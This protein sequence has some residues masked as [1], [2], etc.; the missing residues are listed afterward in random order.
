MRL[1]ALIMVAALAGCSAPPPPP[2]AAPVDQMML[3]EARAGGLAFA[4]DRPAEAVT[5]YRAAL[6]RARLRDDL[7]SITDA[8]TNLAVAE[9]RANQPE[10]ALADARATR[11]ELAR[12]GAADV[13]VLDLVE[14]TALY[15]TGQT[16]AADQMASLV[17]RAGDP[18][19]AARASFLRGLIADAHGDAAGLAAA[20]QALD[21]Q[22]DSEQAADATELESRQQLRLRNFAAARTYAEQAASLRR[23]LPDYRGLARDLALAAQAAQ[24]QGD[25]Q[26][27][28]D[29]Y[30]RAGRSA[31]VQGN[32]ADARIWLQHAQSG[33]PA[34]AEQA[35]QILAALAP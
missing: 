21:P 35:R 15:R 3:N 29:L 8:G 20:R 24:G 1:L 25:T 28:S 5:H 31:A 19:A 34:V 13:P 18:Q 2:V 33:D 14:A 30:L 10:Q 4:L 9:L 27:A 17:Q 26:A 12:R 7:P 16:A 23:D 32:N 22:V 6:A 11:G